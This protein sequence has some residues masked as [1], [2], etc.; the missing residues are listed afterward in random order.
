MSESTTLQKA[1]YTIKKLKHLLQERQSSAVQPIA[2][3][4]MSCRFPEASGKDALENVMQR[5]QYHF[6][7]A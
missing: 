3:T 6:S 7:H 2:I 1:L 5:P 4:G